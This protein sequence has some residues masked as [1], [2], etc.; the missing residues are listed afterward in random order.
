[1]KVYASG[2][3]LLTFSNW[4]GMDPETGT[5]YADTDGFPVF[6]II[7]VGLNVTF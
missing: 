5:Q 6:K 2:K 3:N 4:E 7:T 1:M